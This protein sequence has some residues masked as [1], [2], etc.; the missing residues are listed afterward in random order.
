MSVMEAMASGCWIVTSDLAGLPETTAGFG[1]LIPIVG[2]DIERYKN[3]FVEETVDVLQKLTA[4][5]VSEAEA[6]LRR[7]VNYIN[8][9]VTWPVR[10]AVDGVVERNSGLI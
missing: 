1:R 5:D 2:E 8:K 9:E 4:P 10:Q 7:Q 6:H 3:H